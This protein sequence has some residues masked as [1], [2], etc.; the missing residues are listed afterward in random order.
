MPIIDKNNE[1]EN[2]KLNLEEFSN[3]NEVQSE[4]SKF[5]HQ[6]SERMKMMEKDIWVIDRF[7]GNYAICENRKTKEK[8]E[9][10][11]E[12]L[13]KEIKEGSVLSYKDGK[14]EVDLEEEK[15]IEERIQK[16]MKSIWNE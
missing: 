12:K 13:P 4:I 8:R 2:Q 16:K 15:K 6:I 7:E 11:K 3:F 10:E 1:L 5:T 14:Y 9:I